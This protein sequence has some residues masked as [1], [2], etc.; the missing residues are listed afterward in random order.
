MILTRIA[1]GSIDE[2][3]CALLHDIAH[4]CFSHTVDHLKDPRVSLH[5]QD[6]WKLLEPFSAELIQIL[7][8]KWV[9]YLQPELWPAVKMNSGL[10]SDVADYTARDAVAFGVRPVEEVREMGRRLH[11][12]PQTRI[13][14]CATHSDAAWWQKLSFN[15]ATRIYNAAWN[16][17]ANQQ[18]A[19]ALA[20]AIQEDKSLLQDLS[21]CEMGY[22]ET[23]YKKLQLSHFMGPDSGLGPDNDWSFRPLSEIMP[24]E[25]RKVI[26]NVI[27]RT[28]IVRPHIANEQ[29]SDTETIDAQ[30]KEYEKP[31]MMP[32]NLW[33]R[34][35]ITGGFGLSRGEFLVIFVMLAFLVILIILIVVGNFLSMRK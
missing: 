23:V 7:G 30:A 11:I 2:Q 14:E 25:W 13:L 24:S 18:L 28:R 26:D 27:M 1:G 9:E 31:L 12:N 32:K 35:K 34:K 4:T 17:A 20:S 16:Y 19:D 8:S 29:A 22:E 3:I 33:S 5:E 10:A 6:K 15:V 21:R